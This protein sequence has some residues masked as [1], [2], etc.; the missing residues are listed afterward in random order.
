MWSP[1]ERQDNPRLARA[2]PDSKATGELAQPVQSCRSP[3]CRPY[4]L[5]LPLSV[6]R[7]LPYVVIFQTPE[8]RDRADQ[9]TPEVSGQLDPPAALCSALAP[10]QRPKR[11]TPTGQ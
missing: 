4:A 8:C 1:Y 5:S 11:A 7:L 10:E 6:A 2:T 9:P 3:L